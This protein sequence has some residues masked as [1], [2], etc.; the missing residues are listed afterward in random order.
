MTE[1]RTGSTVPRRQVGRQLREL[2]NQAR[3]TAKAAALAMDFS[4]A[5]LFR[6][7]AGDVPMRALE[8]ERM[9]QIYGAPDD[10]TQAMVSLARETKAK[11]WWQSYSDVISENTAV[12]LGLEE[13]A[14]AL[15]LYQT[16]VID[17]L[18]QTET[19]T[20]AI[21][22]ASHPAAESL[23]VETIDRIAQLR[24][25][26]QKLLTRPTAPLAVKAVIGEAALRRPIGGP[27]AMSEQLDHLS[28]L[29]KLPNVEIRVMPLDASEHRGVGTGSFTIVRFPSSGNGRLAEPPT[30]Y[31]EGYLGHLY[32]DKPQEID[33]YDAA[34]V[35]IWDAALDKRGSDGFIA[36]VRKELA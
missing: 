27:K 29:N 10:L 16:D 21:V 15:S 22:R 2:R 19:Y 11:G 18:F 35:E 36:M 20:R 30:V 1:S 5:K 14:S 8:V 26:R 33:R 12:Y 24:L 23:D 9:C 6:M 17:G 25:A 28:G 13:A 32:L 7:E 3:M 4:E 34:W 31:V